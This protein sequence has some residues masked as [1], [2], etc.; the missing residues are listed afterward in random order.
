MP[1]LLLGGTAEAR[2]LAGRLAGRDDLKLTLSLAG[3]TENPVPQPVPVRTGGFG[4][5]EGL[6]QFLRDHAIGA[7]IDATH[8][9]AAVISRNAATA[10]AAVGVPLLALRRAPWAR[11]AGDLWRDVAD[12]PAAV[13]A[14]GEA[15][16]RVFLALGRN[17][18][19]AFAAA[20]QHSYV[21]RSV[22]PV[23]PPL[24]VPDAAYVVARGPFAEDDERALLGG[25]G[26]EIIVA[27]N[28]GGAATYAKMA[29]ARALGIEVLLLRRPDMPEVEAVESLDEAVAWVERVMAERS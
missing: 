7:V 4:G 25:H 13:E 5:V 12:V 9:Y 3:R 27:K 6:A 24:A 15:P 29:A 26:I 8:P 19:R 23:V 11:Q 28:S 17:E 18:V 10:C 21:I 14:L 16:R 20:P 22:D 2:R 1:L